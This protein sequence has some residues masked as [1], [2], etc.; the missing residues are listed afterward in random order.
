MMG[1]LIQNSPS[2]LKFSQNPLQKELFCNQIEE[3]NQEDSTSS[4]GM[5]TC[6]MRVSCCPYQLGPMLGLVEHVSYSEL[7]ARP[8]QL[9]WW[10][11]GVLFRPVYDSPNPIKGSSTNLGLSCILGSN[12]DCQ[13]GPNGL[14]WTCFESSSTSEIF[15]MDLDP[16][17]LP[18][19]V[20][21]TIH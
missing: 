16:L 6:Y 20:F 9:G 13:C 12:W 18:N 2:S 19:L 11:L 5:Y 7:V 14:S 17:G 8:E 21:D 1:P 4:N 15:K 10:L 3:R